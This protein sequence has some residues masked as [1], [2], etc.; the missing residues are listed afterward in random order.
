MS[1]QR[2][3]P[4]VLGIMSGTSADGIDV[5]LVRVS[6]EKAKLENF[7]ALPFPSRV[8]D[9]ILRLGEGQ[10]TTTGEMSQLNF[11]L[12]EIL[13]DAALAA[14]R[15]FRVPPSQISLIG[16]HGQTVF[17]QGTATWFCG[18]RVAST[19]QIGEPSVIAQRTGI[20]TV[21]DFRPADMAVGGQGAPLVP[22]VDYFLYRDRRVGRAA[23]NIG[24]IANVT[25]IPRAAKIGDV[26]AFDIGPGNMVI[27]A[28]VRRF[29]RGRK[30]FDRNAEMAVRGEVLPGVLRELLRNPYFRK[31]PPKTAGREQ[32][33]EEY[34]R[35]LLAHREARRA[36]PEEVIRT[37][38]ILTALSI[39]DAIHRF[40]PAQAGVSELIVSGGGAHNPL[41]MAQIEAALPGIRL[42]KS[43]EF[44]VP[45][46]AK[47][48]FAFAL[49][50][51]ETFQRRASNVPGAT[52]ARKTVVLGKVCYAG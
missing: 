47:E 25:V 24:G 43:D 28:L 17:H 46:D 13:A 49:L 29:S 44:G 32:Y 20:A 38:T 22:F 41:L 26:F 14:C 36:R 1:R 19:L 35:R 31:A 52:G 34:V 5:A 9:A 18:R 21:G 16:S 3:G 40:V 33:G 30:A 50:G 27:D 48:A 23:L 45:G 2:K 39:V 7:A 42:R 12:G 37:A 10:P 51:W 8:R 6:N 11:L 15:K 4:L